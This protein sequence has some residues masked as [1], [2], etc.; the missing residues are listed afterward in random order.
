MSV[1]S[2]L[3]EALVALSIILLSVE[4]INV[5]FGRGGVA[6]R[7]PATVAFSFGL[8]HG[9]AFA[10]ALSEIGLPKNAVYLSLLLFNIGVE[11]GQLLFIALL[12][13]C[14][15]LVRFNRFAFPD[16]ARL[17][18]PYFIGSCSTLWFVQRLFA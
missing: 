11:A 14:V 9:A 8:L 15:V 16:W 6:A 12:F 13:F 7:F 17:I 18:P 10:G 4:P 3:I 2:S 5:H 1:Q